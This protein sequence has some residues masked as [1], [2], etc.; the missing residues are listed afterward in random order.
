MNPNDY[1]EV[2]V[3]KVLDKGA[4]DPTSTDLSTYK[5]YVIMN[6][7][8]LYRINSEIVPAPLPN[9][10]ERTLT[11]NKVEIKGIYFHFHFPPCHC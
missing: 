9:Y 7:D 10:P 5:D 3:D 11:C 6:G 4:N 1:G 2:I 8:R